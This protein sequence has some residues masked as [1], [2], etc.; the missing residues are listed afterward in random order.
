[1]RSLGADHVI[2]YTTHDFTAG[3]ERYDVVF[4]NVGNGSLSEVRRVLKPGG[5]YLPNGGGT[6]DKSAS[7]AGILRLLAITPLISQKI[8]LFVASPTNDD[9]QTLAD[10]MRAGQ[11]S[12]VIDRCYPLSEAAEAMRHLETGHA[13]GEI[14]VTMPG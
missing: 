7:I 11:L 12:T 3:R 10:L 2:D 8:R 6:P 4:D 14:V 1:V 13:R 9:L 5:V